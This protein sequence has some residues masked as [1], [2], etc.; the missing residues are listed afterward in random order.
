M[1]GRWT[2]PNIKSTYKYSPITSTRESDENRQET[3]IVLW[4]PYKS[5][6]LKIGD[7]V[8]AFKPN[9]IERKATS[10]LD[11]RWEGSYKNYWNSWTIS[12]QRINK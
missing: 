8:Y 5:H 6:N 11:Y 12:Y 3:K 1:K 2:G 9:S 4:Y 10:K 7:L